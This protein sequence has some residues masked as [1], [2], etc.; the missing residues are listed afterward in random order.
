MLTLVVACQ[1]AAVADEAAEVAGP[2]AARHPARVI[3]VLADRDAEPGITAD[4]SLQCAT[5]G[6]REQ[7]S[8]EVVRLRAGGEPAL[9][10]HSVIAPLLL[11]DVPVHLWVAGAPPLDQA[12]TRETLELCQHILL[13]SARYADSAATLRRLAEAMRRGQHVPLADLAWARTAGW[14]VQLALT[15][16]RHDLRALIPGI[17]Q[18]EITSHGERTT[19][20]LLLAG[21][22]ESRL[23]ASRPAPDIV[24]AEVTGEGEAPLGDVVALRVTAT[25]GDHSA[26]LELARS[27]DLLGTVAVL[28][29]EV[30][31]SRTS[32]SK[33]RTTADLVAAL[34]AAD[35]ED[36]LYPAALDAASRRLAR[37]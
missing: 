19:D 37:A 36:P 28:D 20:A 7:V 17:Q 34:I 2:I 3:I 35:T 9:H 30:I 6:G 22:L 31:V 18:I 26:R 24:F 11:P 13:D 8:A 27:G 33:T 16:D 32:P 5:V 1:D 25:L 10:L 12:V 29:D 15:L 4:L 21:W 14:R 23:G